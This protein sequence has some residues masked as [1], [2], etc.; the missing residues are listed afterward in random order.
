MYVKIGANFIRLG[1][2]IGHVMANEVELIE[3]KEACLT[4]STISNEECL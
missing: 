4:E 2:F 1:I 3:T